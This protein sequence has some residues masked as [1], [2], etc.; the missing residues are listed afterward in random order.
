MIP[1]G[2]LFCAEINKLGKEKNKTNKQIPS[3]QHLDWVLL[4]LV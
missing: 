4:D 1:R 3:Q 2:L